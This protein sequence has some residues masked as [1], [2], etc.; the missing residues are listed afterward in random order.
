MLLEEKRINCFCKLSSIPSTELL[1]Y[2]LK[3]Y[4]LYCITPVSMYNKIVHYFLTKSIVLENGRCDF[5]YR[6]EAEGAEDSK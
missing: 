5:E 6:K 4:I 2:L 1:V 3:S